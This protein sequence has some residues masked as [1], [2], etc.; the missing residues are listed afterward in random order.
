[1]RRWLLGGLVMTCLGLPGLLFAA[2]NMRPIRTLIDVRTTHSDGMHDMAALVGMAKAR[3]IQ[4]LA[5]VDHGRKGIRFGIEPIPHILGYTKDFRSL[6][7][8]GLTPF[9]AGLNRVRQA[10]PEMVLF[11]GAESIAGYRWSGIPFKNLALHNSERMFITLGEEHPDQIKALPSYTLKNTR[12]DLPVSVAFWT[13][14]V[15]V[16]IGL[17]LR[18]RQ[19]G[20]A[21]LVGAAFIA[22]LASLLVRQ[23]VDAD[24]DFIAAAHKQGLFV[25]WAYPGTQ[26]GVRP[27]PMG[28]QLD[29]PP[30][31][32]RVFTEPTADAFAAVY[33]DN[34]NNTVP[35]GLWDRYLADYMTGI[36]AHPIWAMAAGDFHGQGQSGEY[37]GN[38]PMDV[39]AGK[40]NPASILT[41]MKAGHMVAWGLPRNRNLRVSSLYLE[42][43]LGKRMLPGDEA[44][45]TSQVAVHVGINGMKPGK[46]EDSVPVAPLLTEIIVDGRVAVRLRLQPGIP[47]QEVL[48]LAPGPHIIRLRIPDQAGVR[49][50]ANPFLVQVPG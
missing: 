21:L 47:Q 41:A 39:W 49:M 15:F 7:T 50:V 14:L 48:Q 45:V 27:G 20:V 42:D 35:G 17:L 34:D 18:R 36:R 16:V 19:R 30:Y 8:T 46:Q 33:G 13:L 2:E 4:A 37:L 11:A 3:G 26:S 1:M 31:S 28:V 40:N 9:F 10:H 5:F 32:E 44:K 25:T 6:Y 12:G 24:A 22:F 23:A 38:F 29:T 43:V